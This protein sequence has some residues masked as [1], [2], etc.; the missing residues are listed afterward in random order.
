MEAIR[1]IRAVDLVADQLRRG[2]LRGEFAPGTALPGERS[3]SAQLGV[4]RL[5]LRAALAR[6][7]S[8]GMLEPRQ[9]DAVRVLDWRRR[10][11]LSL[12]PHLL[13]LQFSVLRGFLELRRILAAEAAALACRRATRAQ[14]GE[15]RALAELQEAETDARAFHERDLVFARKFLETA[16]NEALVLLF[17]TVEEVY[18]AHPEVADALL[19]NLDEIRPSYAGIVALL[20]A[21][22]ADSARQAIRAV[23]E[24]QDERA[25][26]RLARARGRKP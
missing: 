3:L 17:N 14:L 25:L 26:R 18:R 20:E 9:G 4:S 23:L 1:T 15:L 2:I 21:G 10:G 12:L 11:S 22:D 13:E 7:E 6:L 8:E 5:T 24:P 19:A 16:G